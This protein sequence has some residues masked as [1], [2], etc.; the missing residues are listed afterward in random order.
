MPYGFKRKCLSGY[1]DEW[2]YW[3]NRCDIASRFGPIKTTS[4]SHINNIGN[5][6]QAVS[7]T[8]LATTASPSEL[9]ATS[10]NIHSLP[11]SRR[12]LDVLVACNLS[13]KHSRVYILLYSSK[14]HIHTEILPYTHHHHHQHQSSWLLVLLLF[15][16]NSENLV[17]RRRSRHCF[18][19]RYIPQ[20]IKCRLRPFTIFTPLHFS[21]S[22]PTPPAPAKLD[23]VEWFG[24][25]Q[26]NN[27]G[28]HH[29]PPPPPVKEASPKTLPQPSP[30]NQPTNI[31][32]ISSL[33]SL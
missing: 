26:D 28:H 29:A 16:I 23:L 8:P 20:G 30:T 13:I 27:C 25:F 24:S 6:K 19:T 11:S 10:S 3:M 14:Q 15:S 22:L 18:T 4:N 21:P 31:I 17:R 32:I 2:F 9:P 7:P 33:A 12:D 5:C 1:T